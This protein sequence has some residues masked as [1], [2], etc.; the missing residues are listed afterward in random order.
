MVR[1]R[2]LSLALL[3]TCNWACLARGAA[4]VTPARPLVPAPPAKPAPA[5]TYGASASYQSLL[6]ADLSS[7]GSVASDRL[8]FSAGLNWR[9]APAF[10]A[11]VSLNYEVQDWQFGTPTAFV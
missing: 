11:G 5:F 7:G 8:S 2:L 1:R 9:P 10:S 6:T 4:Q 3:T